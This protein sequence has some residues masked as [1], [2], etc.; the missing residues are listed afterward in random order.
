[1][2][3][4]NIGHNLEIM[5]KRQGLTQAE[6]AEAVDVTTDHIDH[7]ENGYNGLS[8]LRLL[9]LCNVLEVTPNDILAGEYIP[10]KTEDAN[11]LPLDCLEPTDKVFICKIYHF[12]KNKSKF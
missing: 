9:M 2:N 4:V 10:P 8:I 5:R 6:L 12:L 3:K 1:M 7:V 11:T